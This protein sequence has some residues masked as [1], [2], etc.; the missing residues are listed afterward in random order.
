MDGRFA[1]QKRLLNDFCKMAYEYC[2]DGHDAYVEPKGKKAAMGKKQRLQKQSRSDRKDSA[3]PEDD[4][5]EPV[6]KQM[7]FGSAWDLDGK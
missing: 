2:R 6:K 1:L 5:N 4:T 3:L 7:C